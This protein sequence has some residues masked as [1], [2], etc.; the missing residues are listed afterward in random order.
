MKADALRG[1]LDALLL[2]VLDDRPRHG[3]AIIEALQERSGG[4]LN[5]PTGTVYPALRR[6]ERAG[7][8]ESSW[9]TVGGRERRT[10]QLTVAGRRC[11]SAERSAWQEFADTI[12]GVLMPRPATG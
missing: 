4:V 6:M 9:S 2:A 1:H 7:L 11:L 3:Y 12:G 10:Y 5:L 8:V